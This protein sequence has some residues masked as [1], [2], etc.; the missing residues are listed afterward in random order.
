MQSLSPDVDPFVQDETVKSGCWNDPETLIQKTNRV[1]YRKG[2]LSGTGFLFW[3]WNE[4]LPSALFDW[5]LLCY[6]P[7]TFVFSC[8]IISLMFWKRLP[9]LSWT[10]NTQTW[11]GVK[12]IG[13]MIRWEKWFVPRGGEKLFSLLFSVRKESVETASLRSWTTVAKQSS[14]LTPDRRRETGNALPHCVPVRYRVD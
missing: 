12:V 14:L 10:K 13:K 8:K 9:L 7:G 3:M 6:V 11:L 1:V 4:S 2:S 5:N